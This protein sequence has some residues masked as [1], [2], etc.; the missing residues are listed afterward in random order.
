MHLRINIIPH[1]WSTKSSQIPAWESYQHNM[2]LQCLAHQFI[3]IFNTVFLN[4]YLL[5]LIFQTYK[6]V[7]LLQPPF[8]QK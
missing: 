4:I 6:P 5:S 3:D 2:A 1:S 8:H 7:C